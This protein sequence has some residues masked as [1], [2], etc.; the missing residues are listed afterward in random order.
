MKM[1]VNYETDK[2]VENIVT[3]NETRDFEE[4]ERNYNIAKLRME[5]IYNLKIQILLGFSTL[6]RR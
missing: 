2:V 1:N 3:M 4:L 6:P 5:R